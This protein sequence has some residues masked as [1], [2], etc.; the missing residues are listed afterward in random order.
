MRSR[1]LLLANIMLAAVFILGCSSG[2]GAMPTAPEGT[3]SCMFRRRYRSV[4]E[5]AHRQR[6]V[7][8]KLGRGVYITEGLTDEYSSR[9]EPSLAGGPDGEFH[10]TFVGILDPKHSILYSTSED[11][12]DW[13]GYTPIFSNMDGYLGQVTVDVFKQGIYSIV[14]IS[15]EMDGDIWFINSIDGGLTFSDPVMMSDGTANSLEPDIRVDAQDYV[16][17]AWSEFVEKLAVVDN[18]DIHYRRAYL[19]PG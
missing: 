1:V 14:V 18:Y 12:V 15:F 8:R 5:D 19:M 4:G 11:G 6:R 2:Y 7:R 16:H 10:A 3:S 9:V 13:P 17:F